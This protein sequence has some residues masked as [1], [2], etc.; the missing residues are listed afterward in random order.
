MSFKNLDLKKTV[1][2][3]LQSKILKTPNYSYLFI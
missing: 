2:G 3:F 1:L